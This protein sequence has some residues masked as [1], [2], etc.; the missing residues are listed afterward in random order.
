MFVGRFGVILPVLGI[1]GGLASK[2]VIPAGAGSF[3]TTGA[4]W[5]GLLAAVILIV[6]GLT[7]LPALVLG[8]IA[9]QAQVAASK[10]L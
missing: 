6:G 3:P 5:I 8:P 2:R 10:L 1:A 7:F 9:D 4:L